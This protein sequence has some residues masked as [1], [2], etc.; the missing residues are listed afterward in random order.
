MSEIDELIGWFTDKENPI[1]FGLYYNAEPDHS[2][3]AHDIFVSYIYLKSNS[4]T[5]R[6]YV[7]SRI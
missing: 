1:N 4:Q 2:M 5:I 3:H 6:V 7:F